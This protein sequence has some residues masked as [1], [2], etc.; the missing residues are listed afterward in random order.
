MTIASDFRTSE[1][2][3][4]FIVD[5]ERTMNSRF[6]TTHANPQ[7]CDRDYK[8]GSDGYSC[9]NREDQD[10]HDQL[11]DVESYKAMVGYHHHRTS[12]T[13]KAVGMIQT[14]IVQKLANRLSSSPIDLSEATE[15]PIDPPEQYPDDWADY[16]TKDIS[17][18][19]FAD[20][21]DYDE[22]VD[23]GRH[24][25]RVN[26]TNLYGPGLHSKPNQM[27][28][29]CTVRFC[30]KILSIITIAVLSAA[31]LGFAVNML[32]SHMG[33]TAS[34]RGGTS[35]DV[36][37]GDFLLGETEEYLAVRNYLLHVGKL[38]YNHKYDN[39]DPDGIF[40]VSTTSE[41]QPLAK[42]EILF[43]ETTPQYLAAQWLAHGDASLMPIPTK[44]HKEF[45]QRYAMA[46]LYFA[47]GGN[48]WTRSNNF[49]SS[50]HICTWKE[51]YSLQDITI[52]LAN[53]VGLHGDDQTSMIHGVHECVKDSE[54]NFYPRALYLRKYCTL[55]DIFA[56]T[57][58]AESIK[59][60]R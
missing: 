35:I 48:E 12:P 28:P 31:L 14:K 45:N 24:Q 13:Q 29:S 25:D 56:S 47:L 1:M 5:K 43:N 3:E 44:N 42:Q 46:V 23:V 22:E 15:G 58:S 21:D 37:T 11:P 55:R 2:N 6:N 49:M 33:T 27:P 38:P 41:P 20:E 52:E 10:V 59:H 36:R 34:R 7:C 40:A 50:G 54:G 60:I 17:G 4:E 39:Y 57:A 26:S 9:E 30:W 53:L 18:E 8:E 19:T 16:L 51:E 32:S